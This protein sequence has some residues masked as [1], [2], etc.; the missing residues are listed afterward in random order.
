M[1]ALLLVTAYVFILSQQTWGLTPVIASN[2]LT[3]MVQTG[4]PGDMAEAAEQLSRLEARVNEFV[5]YLAH[6]HKDD[7][8]VCNIVARWQGRLSEVNALHSQEAAYSVNKT[9]VRICIRD[10]RGNL[11]DD[12]T[13]MFILIHELGHLSIDDYGHTDEFWRSFRFLLKIAIEDAKVYRIQDFEEEP[14]EYCHHAIRSSP[15][16]CYKNGNCSLDE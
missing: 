10:S 11:Q 7:N 1:A 9:E 8:R 15:Y 3:Y 14:V 5:N 12:N 2:G 6:N 13:A 16:T 4:A